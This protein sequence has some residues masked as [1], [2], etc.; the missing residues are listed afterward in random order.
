M[1][2]VLS[3]VLGILFGLAMIRYVVNPLRRWMLRWVDRAIEEI[4]GFSAE[5]EAH[6]RG[7]WR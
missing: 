6:D 3:V 7:L 2:T 4:A 5:E 1:L